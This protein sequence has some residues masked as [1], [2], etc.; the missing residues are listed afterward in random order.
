M[1]RLSI[2]L[3]FVC[4]G[5]CVYANKNFDKTTNYQFNN[6]Q[7]YVGEI[8]YLMPLTGSN[9]KV[10]DMFDD[11][12]IME[13][14][15]NFMDYSFNDDFAHDVFYY[16]YKYNPKDYRDNTTLGT[17]KRHIE[18]H[19]FLVNDVKRIDDYKYSWVLYLTDLNTGDKLKYIYD[20][21]VKN[22]QIDFYKFPFVVEKHYNYLKSLIGT[23]LV[24]GTIK[25]K[26]YLH[27]PSYTPN[28]IDIKTNEQ[29]NYTNIYE[30]WIIKDVIINIYEYS[31]F[32]VVSNGENTTTVKY[33]NQYS[34]NHPKYN[35]GNRVFTEKQW[36]ELVNKYGEQHMALIMQNK[37]SDD[38][39]IDEK[40]MACG[41][42]LK[43]NSNSSDIKEVGKILAKTTKE[44]VSNTVKDIKDVIKVLW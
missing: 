17:H 28:Y 14:Y 43:N 31:I 30:K 15:C 2:I 27:A 23:N 32:F 9:M 11:N 33:N 4:F 20:G 34:N 8:L 18:G 37:V 7:N 41:K 5:I 16:Q 22:T 21:E 13:H 35:I 42:N 36:N 3:S 44:N 6:V 38:M 10:V 29:I 24:F 25:H 1:K 19:R 40:Y 26:T 12:H 39:T